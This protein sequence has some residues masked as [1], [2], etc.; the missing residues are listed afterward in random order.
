MVLAL[1][2]RERGWHVGVTAQGRGTEAGLPQVAA[3]ARLCLAGGLGSL[4][5]VQVLCLAGTCPLCA[6]G[7]RAGAEAGPELGTDP[8]ASFPSMLRPPGTT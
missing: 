4:L 8:Q 2:V 6:G 5:G 3:P 7:G 1:R